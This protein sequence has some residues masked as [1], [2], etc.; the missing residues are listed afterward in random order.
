MEFLTGA[1][2]SMVSLR[3]GRP[4]APAGAIGRLEIRK[5]TWGVAPLRYALPQAISGQKCRNPNAKTI[6]GEGFSSEAFTEGELIIL[7]DPCDVE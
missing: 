5:Q 3:C 1:A 7:R 2:L 4:W 6:V